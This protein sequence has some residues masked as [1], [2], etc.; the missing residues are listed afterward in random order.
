[1][2]IVCSGIPNTLKGLREEHRKLCEGKLGRDCATEKGHGVGNLRW[3][4]SERLGGVVWIS[5]WI[6]RNTVDNLRKDELVKVYSRAR[7]S[8]DS[9]AYVKAFLAENLKKIA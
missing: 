7:P 1:M 2:P 5:L 4:R 3:W 6:K 8:A 9:L